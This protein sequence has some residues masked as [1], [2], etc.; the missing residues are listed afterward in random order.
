LDDK[1]NIIARTEGQPRG[2]SYPTTVWKIDEIVSD[3]HILSLPGD[4]RGNYQLAFGLYHPTT[5]ERLSITESN[6]QIL[7]NH[8]TLNITL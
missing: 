7:G 5:G 6:G 4:L 3:A 8:L 1:G 2:G